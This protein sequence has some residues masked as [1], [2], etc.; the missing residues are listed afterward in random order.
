V[1]PDGKVRCR[2]CLEF[3]KGDYKGK[4]VLKASFSSHATHP[5]HL[6]AVANQNIFLTARAQELPEH[7][8]TS[9]DVIMD[10]PPK[11]RNANIYQIGTNEQE[12]VMW[13]GFDGNFEFE[14]TKA[15]VYEQKR[16]EFDRRM[17]EYGLWGGLEDLPDDD[18][19]NVEQLWQEDEQDD[20]LSELLEHAGM[21]RFL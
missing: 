7:Y 21:C 6:K 17:E 15:D 10:S 2:I 8:A 13:D 14:P 4:W 20:L 19:I 18:M 1:G 12:Q 5:I 9:R 11:D 3:N 16:K